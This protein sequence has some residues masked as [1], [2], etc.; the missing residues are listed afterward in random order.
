MRSR[1][2]I[3]VW[4]YDEAFYAALLEG[5]K[6]IIRTDPVKGKGL[7]AA[8]T[9]KKGE[10]IHEET[11]LACS[12]NMDD[13]IKR[14]PVCRHCLISLETPRRVVARVTGSKKAALLLPFGRLVAPETP[15]KCRFAPQGCAAEF[16]SARCR[17]MGW[18]SYH[19]VLCTGRMESSEQRRAYEDFYHVDWV[20]NGVDYSDSAMVALR[21]VGLF[22]ARR[23]LHG[24]SLS[25]SY[26]P[27]SQLIKAPLD[28]FY[29]SYL[30][31]SCGEKE[32]ENVGT[33]DKETAAWSLADQKREYEALQA[34]INDPLSC[35]EVRA[36]YSAGERD[37]ALFISQTLDIVYRMLDFTDAEMDF[38]TPECWSDL[39][40]AVLLNGQE[41]SPPSYYSV[42]KDTVEG[43][44]ADHDGEA[45]LQQFEEELSRLNKD[46]EQDALLA[47]THGQGIYAV[48][49]LF[50][51]SCAP[52]IQVVYA[53]SNDETLCVMAMRDIERDEELCISYIEEDMTFP[54]RQQQLYEHYLFECICPKCTSDAAEF[55]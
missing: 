22:L 32:E 4:S 39:F 21:I 42:L 17:E 10:I 48:G 41:R 13:R 12:Q 35:E 3:P 36:S 19:A 25:E 8:G 29:F 46:V 7:F 31:K 51:H 23:R 26:L 43:A 14:I 15:V 6:M 24:M 40:G 47:S 44:L 20:Q 1:A 53:N 28:K 5:T 52:N 18:A 49:C 37:K 33:G 11:A 16:C 27:F 2:C 54:K 45:K 38:F 50:N 55:L 30:V 9:I 34:V